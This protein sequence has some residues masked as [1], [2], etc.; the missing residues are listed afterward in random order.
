MKRFEIQRFDLLSLKC[1][2]PVEWNFSSFVI[3][4]FS[5]IKTEFENILATVHHEPKSPSWYRYGHRGDLGFRRAVHENGHV[6]LVCETAPF[7]LYLQ[8][9]VSRLKESPGLLWTKMTDLTSTDSINRLAWTGCRTV[10]Y[11]LT[12]LRLQWEWRNNGGWEKR[13]P[14]LACLPGSLHFVHTLAQ[15]L[16]SHIPINQSNTKTKIDWT[17]LAK[18]LPSSWCATT[19]LYN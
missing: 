19:E 16:W 11:N 4:F 5:E 17:A 1:W 6:R 9:L 14:G 2:L 13:T 10:Y 15:F 8:K 12:A 7:T 3:K 18:V